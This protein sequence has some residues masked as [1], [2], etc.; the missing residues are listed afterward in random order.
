MHTPHDPLDPL[1]ERWRGA[2]PPLPGPLSSEVWRRIAVAET[3]APP[4][5]LA[6]IEAAFARPSFAVAFVAAC[7]LFGLFMAEM[8]LSRLQAERN[9]QLARSYLHL[10]DPLL[11][12]TANQSVSTNSGVSTAPRS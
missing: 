7:V 6:R 5:L 3:P 2:P 1:L 4:G 10:I 11:D 9:T 8:R 12:N